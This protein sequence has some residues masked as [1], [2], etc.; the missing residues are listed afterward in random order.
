MTQSV[1]PPELSD[2]FEEG[3][4]F[5]L[6]GRRI[7]A[8]DKGPGGASHAVL[9]L[10]GY[11]S[12]SHDWRGMLPFLDASR[13]VVLVDLPGFGLSEKPTDYSY[14]VHEQAD[15]IEM[16]MVRFGVS[17]VDVVSHDMGTTI[18]AEL[19]ARRERKL[20]GFEI[21]STTFINGGAFL[22]FA[23][24]A[25]RVASLTPHALWKDITTGQLFEGRIRSLF[26][27]N[28]GNA[29]VDAMWDQLRYERGHLRLPQSGRYLDERKTYLDRWSSAVIHIEHPV[30]VL[31]SDKSP[32]AAPELGVHLAKAIKGTR[33]V[34][35]DEMG[36]Y[37]QLEAP[38]ETAK[39][40]E[41]F[42][43]TCVQTAVE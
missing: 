11:P 26:V 3:D 43:R 41:D 21:R 15:F 32:V 25:G 5:L 6:A 35:M 22:D 40:L 17:S 14:S 29:E 18:A 16:A 36:H 12:S 42:W 2:W 37:P 28:V 4:S 1:L 13:R 33:L 23:P 7:F 38:E 10:H 24:K 27:R 19:L 20:L 31:W 34:R 8:L 30:L 39:I 9:L